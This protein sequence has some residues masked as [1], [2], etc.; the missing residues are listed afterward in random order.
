MSHRGAASKLSSFGNAMADKMEAMEVRESSSFESKGKDIGKDR[1]LSLSSVAFIAATFLL[2]LL[3]S[4]KGF[5]GASFRGSISYSVVIDCGSTGSRVHIYE[6]NNV[7]G[8]SLPRVEN[9]IFKQLKPGLSAYANDPIKGAESLVPLLDAAVA[10]IPE[11]EHGVTPLFVGATAGLRLLPGNQADKLLDAVR[12]L[13]RRRYNFKF[14]PADDVMI[15]SGDD[16]GKFA[17]MATNMLL[18]LLRPGADTVGVVDLGGGS[19][20]MIRAVELDEIAMLPPEK[21]NKVKLGT[22]EIFLYVHSFL[23]Y[24][25]MAARKQIL[26]IS[27]AS[28]AC[29]PNSYQGPQAKYKYG[30]ETLSAAGGPNGNFQG[31]LSKTLMTLDLDDQCTHNTCTFDGEWAG[32]GTAKEQFYM[33]SYIYERIDQTGAG[34]FSSIGGKS[35]LQRIKDTAREICSM[36]LAKLN[37]IMGADEED[38]P[39]LCMDLSYIYSLLNIGLGVTGDIHLAKKF[40]SSNGKEFEAAWALGAAMS[41]MG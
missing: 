41:R 19:A 3:L 22:Q 28:K 17:W 40:P 31:C 10:A 26:K 29:M 6:F 11:S 38:R 12:L 14:S 1:K 36:P 25:L 23:N 4:H 8:S 9:E 2:L 32:T 24:G 39:Y 37:S 18:G 5:A 7:G 21:I 35:S 34:D 20:Q 33:L 13:L 27:G 15:L 30:G 16:E